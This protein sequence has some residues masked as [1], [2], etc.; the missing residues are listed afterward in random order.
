MMRS[1]TF[2]LML[3]LFVGCGG[4]ER[5]EPPAIVKGRVLHNGR[6]VTSA[7][8]YFEKEG[9][10]HSVFATLTADGTFQIKTF[11]YGGLPQG[12]YR[13]AIK[14]V[15][16]D[17]VFLVGDKRET[18]NHPLIPTRFTQAETSGLRIEVKTGDN[19]PIEWDLAKQPP[20]G[21]D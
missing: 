16:G 11:D 2:A 15:P 12:S 21:N 13:I 3:T 8:V 1:L 18:L 7:V 20:P 17:E 6:P 19:P 9:D 5:R 4:G 10:D 14:P